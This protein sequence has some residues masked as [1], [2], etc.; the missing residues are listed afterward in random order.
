MIHHP[1]GRSD[2]DLHTAAQLIELHAH[3]LPAIDRQHVETGQE[4]RVGLHRLGNLQGQFAGRR[5]HQQLRIVGGGI[6]P[7]QQRQ[8]KGGGLAGAGLRLTEQV[9]TGQEQRDRL[10]LD[11]R[12]CFVTDL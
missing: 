9:P 3:A 5:Q 4:A 12:W 8:R 10:G 7:G 6:D 11:R 1:P 2:H